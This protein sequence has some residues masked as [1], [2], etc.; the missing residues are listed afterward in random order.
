MNILDPSASADQIQL[1]RRLKMAEILR[2]QSMEPDQNQVAGGY[3]I[4]TSPF[5]S[6]NKIASGFLAG[7]MDKDADLQRKGMADAKNAKIADALKNYGKVTDQTSMSDGMQDFQGRPLYTN[8]PQTRTAT[9]DEQMQQDWN[10]SQLDPNFSKVLESRHTRED[11]QAAK[12]EQIRLANELKQSQMQSDAKPFYQPLQTANGVFAFNARTGKVEQVQG[13]NKGAVIGA[14]FDPSLQGKIAG[15]KSGSGELAKGT[16]DAQIKLPQVVSTAN[17]LTRH[18]DELI[19]SPDGKIKP[20]PGMDSYLSSA[21]MAGYIPKTDAAGF[22]ARLEQL[23]GGTFLQAYQTLRGGGQI[24]EVEGAKAT[25]AL[26]RAKAAQNQAEFTSS[27][28]DFQNIVKQGAER[29][30][31]AAQGNYQVNSQNAP[32]QPQVQNIVDFGSLK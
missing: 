17:D 24:T 4:P 15:A 7:K 22:K 32:T 26:N 1:D 5:A 9:P 18:I 19:G 12:L 6:L 27:L 14:Q 21:G 30:K 16:A 25:A 8:T 2:Q 23:Q 11:T 13:P 29:A 28:R 3:V 20:H 31:M 10:L